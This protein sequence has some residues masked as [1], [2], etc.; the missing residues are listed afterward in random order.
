MG[1]HRLCAVQRLDR[2]SCALRRRKAQSARSRRWTADNRGLPMS[3][4]LSTK[5]GSHRQ[6][7]ALRHHDAAAGRRRP[8]C[9]APSSLTGHRG[10]G[11]R[12]GTGLQWSSAP[13]CDELVSSV[14]VH[15]LDIHLVVADLAGSARVASSS[16]RPSSRLSPNG[17]RWH[18]CRRSA[19][20]IG[21]MLLRRSS[22]LLSPS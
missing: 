7:E 22:V 11:H 4:T 8:R 2:S 5:S 1:R 17:R 19:A 9:G 16:S 21:V 10:P 14:R 12:S 18:R 6:L 13:S 20:D 3:R 15:H